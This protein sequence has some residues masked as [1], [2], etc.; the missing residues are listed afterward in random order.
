MDS[1]TLA[2]NTDAILGGPGLINCVG[3]SMA[4]VLTLASNSTLNI[5]SGNDHNL[6]GCIFTNNGT[7]AWTGGRVR[8]GGTPGTTIQNNGLWNVQLDN[9][10][11]NDGGGMGTTFNN[12]GTFRKSVTTGDTTIYGGVFFNQTGG[13]CDVQGGRV[14]LASGGSF[15]GG[16]ATN[17]GTLVLNGGGFLINGTLTTTNVQLNGGTL[18]AGNSVIYGGL[19]W[20]VGVWNNGGPMTIATN[21]LLL[22]TSGNDHDLYNCVLTNN[23]AVAWS[24]GRIRGGADPS[25]TQIYNYGLFDVQN[26]GYAINNDGGG[27][28]GTMLNNYGDFRKSVGT[29]TSSTTIYGGVVFNQLAGVLDTQN[30]VLLLAS[31][32]NFTGGFTTTNG[33][34]ITYLNAGGFNLNGTVTSSN[35]VQ[36]AGNLVGTNII[37]GAL[38]WQAGTWDNAGAV[39]LTAGSTLFINNTADHD[40]YN[41]G[42]TNNGSV[43]WTAGRIRGGADPYGTQIYN[44]GLFDVQNDGY[45]VQDDGGGSEGTTIDNYGTFRKSVG[46]N[47][48]NTLVNSG[49]VFN[50]FAG[51]LDTQDGVL[52]LAGGGNFTGGYTTTN[53]TGITYLNVGGF[54]LNGTVTS[55]NVVENAGNLVGIN[56]IRGALQW[57]AGNWDGA[58]PVTVTAGS[59]LYINNPPDH[60]L[61]NCIFTNNGTVLWTGGRIR[62]GGTPGTLIQNNGLWNVQNDGYGINNDFG[63]VGTTLNNFGTFRKSV[64]NNA[65]STP[66]YGGVLF[67]Q[68]GGLLDV[69]SGNLSLQSSGNFTGGTATNIVGTLILNGGGFFINGTITSTNVQLNGGTLAAGNNVVNGGLNW[70]VGSWNNAGAMTIA[71]SSLLLV[72]SANDHDLA[73]CNFT[74]NGTVLWL[75]GRLRGGGNPGTPIYNNGLFDVQCDFALNDD[76]GGTGT[77]FNNAGTLRKELTTGNTA[78]TSG[79]F[80]NHTGNLDVRSGAVYL[81]GGGAFTGGTATNSG[82]IILNAGS[83]LINGTVTSTKVSLNGGTLAAGNSVMN[84][85]LNW[86]VG[87]WNNGGPLTITPGSLLLVTSGNDHN[88]ANCALTNNGTVMWLGGRLRGGGTPGTPIY[89]NGLFDVQCDSSLNDDF[90]GTGTTFNNAGTVRKELTSGVTAFTGGVTFNNT[91]TMDLQNGNVALQGAYTLAN[92]TKMGFGLGGSAGNGSISLSGAASFAGSASVNLNGLFWPAVGSSFSLLN[93]TSESG[94]LF[95]NLALAAPGYISWQTNYSATA[96]VLSVV[97]HIA[98]NTTPT[99]LFISTL[100][101]SNIFLQWSGDHTGWSVQAQT[102]PVTAGIRSNWA[103]IAGTSLTNQFVLPI[104]KANGTVFFRMIYP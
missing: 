100:N 83:F 12:A 16:T 8:G 65:N 43:I 93:Y 84:G 5:T 99:N 78:F 15:T 70:V 7:V 20:V 75:A 11:N 49:V 56:N 67:N 58:G 80:Y 63:G 71:P 39:T 96:F 103:A 60:D 6:F 79:V 81:Q 69:Q 101:S 40:L 64:G 77:T 23:G 62:G 9:V 4:G 28:E 38:Q 55:S 61:A 74:N 3:A 29:N 18:A 54:N 33:T 51:V 90:G 66:I 44:Y 53:G 36:N 31:G 22:I 48:S 97:A 104:D 72:T 98:T 82:A 24:A 73:N 91:G 35:V 10:I 37:R 42:F 21:S 14:L 85:G 19:N 25:G 50:Q 102:N 32:G 30:G 52:L 76:F 41:C 45:S 88:L 13:S 2:G 47:T 89:N 34:G 17:T 46:T 26:D 27:S 68:L 86:V 59:T 95:T 92:G 94:L 87:D 57:Q 1:G